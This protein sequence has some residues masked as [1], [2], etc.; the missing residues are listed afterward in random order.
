MIECNIMVVAEA[1][2]VVG[3][4]IFFSSPKNSAHD[5]NTFFSS[6]NQLDNK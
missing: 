6:K 5:E 2:R 1:Y 3:I 4:H